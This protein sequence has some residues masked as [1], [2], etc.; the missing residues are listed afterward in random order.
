M[1]QEHQEKFKVILSGTNFGSASF[2]SFGNLV[3]HMVTNKKN[4]N[5]VSPFLN[6]LSTGSFN[7]GIKNAK[8]DFD[9]L[10]YNEENVKNPEIQHSSVASYSL[11]FNEVM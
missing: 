7:K 6:K 10:S 11:C 5:K 9:W 1:I 2:M 4:F 8:T 3:S